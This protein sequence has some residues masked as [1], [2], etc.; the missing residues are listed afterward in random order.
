[1]VFLQPTMMVFLLLCRPLAAAPPRP[2]TT[3]GLVE[4]TGPVDACE[5]VRCSGHAFC[6][7]G[8]C[9]CAPG[10]Q[11]PDCLVDICAGHVNGSEL[12]CH[13][14]ASPVPHGFCVDGRCVCNKGW[15]GDDCGVDSCPGHCG[16]HGTCVEGVCVCDGNWTGATLWVR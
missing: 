10:F 4:Q 3:T 5:G 13:A 15:S 14:W 16:G 2:Q 1:M 7:D 11:P 9:H 8:V 12:G 6:F